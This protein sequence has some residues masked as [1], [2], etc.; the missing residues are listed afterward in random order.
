MKTTIIQQA[1]RTLVLGFGLMA[2]AT[3]VVGQGDDDIDGSFNNGDHSGSGWFNNTTLGGYGEL[4]LNLNSNSD[5]EIDFHRWVLFINHRFSDRITLNGEFELEHSLAG[6]GKPGEVE[7]EQA[8]VDIAFDGGT[9]L[10][11]GLF[12]LPV[13]TLNE[14]HEPD[15]FYGVERNPIEKNIIPTTWWEAGLALNGSTE[16]GLAWEVAVHSGLN[17]PASYKIRSGRQ[18]VAEAVAEDAAVTARVTY[19]GSGFSVGGFAQYQ[20]DITQGRDDAD[21]TLLGATLDANMGA[22]RLRGLIAS[23]DIG[24]AAAKAAGADEQWGYY[25][26]P[27]YK[28]SDK[29]GVF[30]RYNEWEDYSGDHDAVSI[31]VNYW[32]IENVVF[33]ADYTDSDSDESFNL[34]VGYSF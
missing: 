10:K 24:G 2:T 18:K 13:G 27:S 31:G 16:G 5:N 1:S 9:H 12:L 11:A 30:A 17:V 14:T 33:K 22:F 28:I 19:S 20:S 3:Q 6:D 23:W 8:Y 29:L 21:A 25:I 26:E 34:G 32:P 15:S 7:L 4:H